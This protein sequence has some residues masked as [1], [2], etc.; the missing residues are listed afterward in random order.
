[1]KDV[2]GDMMCVVLGK[3]WNPQHQWEGNVMSIEYKGTCKGVW[4]SRVATMLGMDMSWRQRGRTYYRCLEGS[5]TG[6]SGTALGIQVSTSAHHRSLTY[7][8][9]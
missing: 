7:K 8:T 6:R 2:K 5:M 9:L 1:M 4:Y 3:M